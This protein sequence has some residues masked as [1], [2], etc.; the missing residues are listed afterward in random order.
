MVI[1]TGVSVV[2]PADGLRVSTGARVEGTV[3]G[4]SELGV[5][6]GT[7]VGMG[8]GTM[9]VPLV[10]RRLGEKEGRSVGTLLEGGTVRME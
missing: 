9:A 6:V 7:M 2:G 4:A 5:I 1:R 8:V 3:V 10:G